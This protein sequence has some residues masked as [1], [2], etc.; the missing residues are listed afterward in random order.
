MATETA[1]PPSATSAT[2][3]TSPSEPPPTT[4]SSSTTTM[5]TPSTSTSSSS[6]SSYIRTTTQNYISRAADVLGPD[7]V[8]VRGKSVVRS[9]VRIHGDYGAVISIGR[10]CHLDEGVVLAPTVVD[11]EVADDDD[12]AET[13]TTTTTTTTKIETLPPTF[14]NVPNH[15]TSTSKRR[16]DLFLADLSPPK[17]SPSQKA[18]P[19]SVGSHTLISKRTVVRSLSIG[20]YVRIGSDCVLHP[21]SIVK[22]CCVIEDGTVIPPEMVVPPFSRVRGAPGRV[23]GCLPECVAGEM[24]ERRVEDFVAFVAALATEEEDEKEKERS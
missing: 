7:R 8:H 23:V 14:S 1:P 16:R 19:L 2:S 11:L 22:D 21:R 3:A 18:L 10:Y 4:T 9:G 15:A 5:N 6:Q 17:T 20:S 13:T 24:A 12:R